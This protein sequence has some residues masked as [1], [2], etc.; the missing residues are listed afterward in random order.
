[1]TG[2]LVWV[3]V[4]MIADMHLKVSDMTGYTLHDATL[5]MPYSL[6]IAAVG[7]LLALITAIMLLWLTG[8]RCTNKLSPSYCI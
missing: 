4:G 8:K 7:A 2:K 1:M 6:V 3:P 5:H